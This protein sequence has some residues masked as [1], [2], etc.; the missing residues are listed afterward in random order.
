MVDRPIASTSREIRPRMRSQSMHLSSHTPAT[1]KEEEGQRTF[2][3]QRTLMKGKGAGK[4]RK[5]SKKS[6]KQ[7]EVVSSDSEDLEVDFPS[8]HPNQPHKA[9]IPAGDAEEPQ[10]P[11]NHNL[12]PTQPPIPMANNQLNWSHFRPQFSGKPEEDAEAHL[13][14]TK[15]WMTTHNFPE[16]QKVGRFCLTLTQEAR[17]WCATLNVQQQQLT[18]EGLL[19]TFRQQYSKFG[20][21]RE[22]Y[23]YVWRSFQFDEAT[24]TIDGYIYKVKQV[25][26]LLDYGEPQIL[27]LFK[28][29]LPS[30]LYCMLYQINDLRVVV[31]TAKRPMIKEQMDKRA[32]QSITSPFM[33][34]S[35]NKDKTEK[36]A[37]FDAVEVM[38]RTSDSIERLATLMD[39]MDT[40]LDRREDQYRP[41]VYQ[42]RN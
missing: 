15:D 7:I 22:Q 37:S 33:Q 24:D 2:S 13:L 21:T 16:D 39:R 29:T 34:A 9:P 25:A 35:Q 18:W 36:K 23:F 8:Y 42:G 27:E 1:P 31:E 41:R 10:N 20:S 5:A 30:R 14:R 17:L 11:G 40:K 6:N 26:A 12:I 19:D 28:N 3:E 32:G 38:E 4:G